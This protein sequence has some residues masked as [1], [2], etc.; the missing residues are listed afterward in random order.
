MKAY[1][2]ISVSGASVMPLVVAHVCVG[3]KRGIMGIH[4]D[5]ES[6]LLANNFTG[7]QTA[8]I[9]VFLSTSNNPSQIPDYL[10]FHSALL[11]HRLVS[12]HAHSG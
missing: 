11:H 5:A 3:G 10:L 12:L 4:E 9:Q 1:A 2:V 8:Y 6:R 7:H